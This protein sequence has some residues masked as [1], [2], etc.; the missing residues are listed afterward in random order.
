MQYLK[1]ERKGLIMSVQ[2]NK[3]TFTPEE[4]LELQKRLGTAK[5]R[6]EAQAIF[7]AY[8][9]EVGLVE[10]TTAVNE[11]APVQRTKNAEKPV[12]GTVVEQNPIN[13]SK[14]KNII[15]QTTTVTA[16][17]SDFIGALKGSV[18]NLDE[19]GQKILLE[20]LNNAGISINADGTFPYDKAK[21]NTALANFAKQNSQTILTVNGQGSE[22][23]TGPLV[24]ESHLTQKDDG[25]FIVNGKEGK[26]AV[27]KAFPKQITPPST[28]RED[29]PLRLN[30]KKT[31]NTVKIENA[32]E[33]PEDLEYNK[34]SR[35]LLEK[36]YEDYLSKE[37]DKQENAARVDTLIASGR[38]NKKIA[39]QEA[40][41]KKECEGR[42]TTILDKYIN[43]YA[44]KQEIEFYNNTLSELD[45]KTVD[46]NDK[47]NYEKLLVKA[48]NDNLLAEKSN[49]PRITSLTQLNKDQ[50]LAADKL[51][52]QEQKNNE[53]ILVYAWNSKSGEKAISSLSELNEGQRNIAKKLAMT[54]TEGFDANI[55]VERMASQD[56][57]KDRTKAEKEKD[58]KWLLKEQAER[59]VKRD[60]TNQRIRNT[61]V[62]FSEEDSKKAKAEIDALV[63]K[64]EAQGLSKGEAMLKAKEEANTKGLKMNNTD[65]GD[66]GRKLVMA[67]PNTFCTAGS[68]DDYDFTKQVNGKTV[69]YKFSEQKYREFCDAL[70]N[71][72]D[73]EKFSK[74]NNLT[75][76]EARAKLASKYTL[77]DEYN[78]PISFDKAMGNG[79]G[80]I[81]NR[82]VNDL[83]HFV[84]AG[85][86]S[87]DKNPTAAK[88]VLHLLTQ[89]GI[90]AGLGWM[91]G[92]LVAELAGN[93]VRGGVGMTAGQTVIAP[94]QVI[95]TPGYHIEQ[96]VNF[97]FSGKTFTKN[98]ITD[99]PPGT[100]IAPP[101]ELYVPGQEYDYQTKGKNI[102]SS[103][104]AGTALGGVA[105]LISAIPGLNKIE[106]AGNYE[107]WTWSTSKKVIETNTE[108]VVEDCTY[109]ILVTNEER[110]AEIKTEIPKLKAIRYR[111]SE[112]YSKM[113][114]YEDGTPVS[115]T[116]FRK[117][118]Q[119]KTG[120]KYMTK[121]YFYLFPEMEINGRKIVPIEDYMT[122]YKK[123]TEGI[124]GNIPNT[125][126]DGVQYKKIHGKLTTK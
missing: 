15:S 25:S 124:P 54:C 98:V 82:E 79:N 84:E 87:I 4:Q 17:F 73:L 100:A 23:I 95:K 35:K 58:K 113:Y 78:N 90:G 101:Q 110:A 116:D 74:D 61:K 114:Q 12:V 103:R 77:L 28:T 104:V 123:I 126:Y 80:K 65:I 13:K 31:N 81:G 32:V 52:R 29:K 41:I 105:G 46:P 50:V 59:L 111:E 30:V 26:E 39:K 68:A 33:I 10:N 112:A 20:S 66:K 109:P 62:S 106:A 94:E 99:I 9:K 70:V 1:V 56:V 115:N 21:I 64:Y 34:D 43:K 67:A 117:A 91:G 119:I 89:A 120:H 76:N 85:G 49:E 75:L 122:E 22:D 121:E 69:Y 102:G 19:N 37:I 8:K 42:E 16:N 125:A 86:Y 93:V 38:Y 11:N 18:A 44:T 45:I 40:K 27:D 107:D 51:A 55:L 88:R 3:T 36:R 53:E 47:E 5:S 97:T 57:I 2:I 6:E 24:K 108:E 92:N 72:S 83:R 71:T 7:D 96:Q 14:D 118:Y 48:W 63:D 60:E